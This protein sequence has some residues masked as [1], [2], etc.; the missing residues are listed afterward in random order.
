MEPAIQGW[1]IALWV[2]VVVVGRIYVAVVVI[3]MMILLLID[4]ECP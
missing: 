4:S 3:V 2:A 1:Q